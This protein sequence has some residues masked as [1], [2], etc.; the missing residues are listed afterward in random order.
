MGDI[1]HYEDQAVRLVNRI[2]QDTFI[3]IADMLQKVYV[4]LRKENMLGIDDS[5]WQWY[6]NGVRDTINAVESEL[7][8]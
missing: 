2:R 6:L 1:N 5:E 8:P 7:K 4:R 3:E